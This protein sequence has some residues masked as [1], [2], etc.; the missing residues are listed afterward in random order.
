MIQH[1]IVLSHYITLFCYATIT[2]N[3]MQTSKS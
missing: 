2:N 3:I 1:L